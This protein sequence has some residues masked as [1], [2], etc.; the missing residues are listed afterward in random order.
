MAY[1]GALLCTSACYFSIWMAG[2]IALA[3]AHPQEP[4]LYGIT[5][6][7]AVLYPLSVFGS[8]YFVGL[9]QKKSDKWFLGLPLLFV[10]FTLILSLDVSEKLFVLLLV[11]AA[12]A[13]ALFILS[14]PEELRELAKRYIT[15]AKVVSVYA[16]ISGFI[17]FLDA[18]SLIDLPRDL[19]NNMLLIYAALGLPSIGICLVLLARQTKKVRFSSS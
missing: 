1:F 15:V 5:T 7:L 2:T 10:I 17:Y 4:V 13:S 18:F 6:A 9:N 3:K 12:P 14:V 11:L 19:V 16:V 8:L